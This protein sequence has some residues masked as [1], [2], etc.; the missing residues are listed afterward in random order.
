[1]AETLHQYLNR[2]LEEGKFKR[3][4]EVKK[5]WRKAY[6]VPDDEQNLILALEE[7][8]G[9]MLPND[10]EYTTPDRECGCLFG[11]I[12]MFYGKT[13]AEVMNDYR[14]GRDKWMKY[15][16]EDDPIEYDFT[17]IMMNDSGEFHAAI[18]HAVTGLSCSMPNTGKDQ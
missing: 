4:D 9:G 13:P 8:C 10:W 16:E 17:L 11:H 14:R 3:G 15:H 18:D 12:S 6:N 1:M 7:E 2:K 5:A